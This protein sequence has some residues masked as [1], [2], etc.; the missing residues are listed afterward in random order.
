[1]LLDFYGTSLSEES[2]TALRRSGDIARMSRKA[3]RILKSLNSVSALMRIMNF[4]IDTSDQEPSVLIL[5]M[6]EELFYVIYV[7][8]Y[9]ASLTIPIDCLLLLR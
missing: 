9:D 2:L 8:L 3:F 6:L 1:M 4:D 7:L 5:K